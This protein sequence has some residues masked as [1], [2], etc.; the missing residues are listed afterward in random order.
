MRTEDVEALRW[1]RCFQG[2]ARRPREKEGR[3]AE[4]VLQGGDEG[5][6]PCRDTEAIERTLAFILS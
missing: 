4:D 1:A 2:S 3:V 5:T 6:R